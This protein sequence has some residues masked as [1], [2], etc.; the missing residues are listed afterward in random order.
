[1]TTFNRNIS[2]NVR[3]YSVAEISAALKND[4]EV[5][6]SHLHVIGE[7]SSVSKSRYGHYYFS[8]KEGQHVLNAILWKNTGLSGQQS[9]MLAAL[10][11]GNEVRVTGR[12]TTYSGS[13][14]YQIVANNI[15]R[16]GEGALLAEIEEL[17]LRLH[18]EGIFKKQSKDRVPYLPKLIGVVTS[19]TGSVIRDIIHRIEDRFPLPVLVWP[20]SVQGDRC[21]SEVVN[22]VTGFNKLDDQS[23]ISKPDVLILARGGGSFEDLLGFNNEDV[24]RAVAT[25]EIP[26]ISAVGHE[27]DTTLVD[28]AANIAAPT[29]TAAVEMVVP[30]R[31]DLNNALEIMGTRVISGWQRDVHNRRIRV[32]EKARLLPVTD[33]LLAFQ[34]QQLDQSASRIT[35][36]LGNSINKRIIAFQSFANRLKSPIS[37]VESRRNLTRLT[38]IISQTGLTQ[39]FS[40]KSYT[41][42]NINQRLQESI[43]K[44]MDQSS[45]KLKSLGSL[46]ASLGYRKTLERGYAVIWEEGEILD[47]RDQVKSFDRLEIEFHDGRVKMSD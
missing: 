22:A 43:K 2:G 14:K 9:R 37:L 12:M 38:A 42:E 23:G 8:L 31:K 27:T 25:S 32:S 7:V 40:M 47:S 39:Q 13:S 35:Y 21:P 3:E 15:N 1:M 4:I 28:Y 33:N 11:E 18:N 29:P 30:V 41:L 24:V 5:K 26:I 19:P 46:L 10:Q 44:F 45:L 36:A 20:A 16:T 6:F 17:R 34:H